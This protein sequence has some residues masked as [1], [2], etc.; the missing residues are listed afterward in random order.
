MIPTLHNLF[1]T[2]PTSDNEEFFT[3]LEGNRFRLEHIISQGEASPPDFWYDQ[4]EPEWVALLAGE[5]ELQ[6]DGGEALS[7]KSGD[8][9]LIP[10]GMKHRVESTSVDAI[11]L[12]LHFAENE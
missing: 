11:W 9:L 2:S 1:N 5:A 7:M 3:L 12:A 6:F 10:A 8:Y 4:E